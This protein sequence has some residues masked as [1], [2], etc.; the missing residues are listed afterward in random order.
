MTIQ[1]N[2]VYNGSGYLPAVG[3]I[4][5]MIR[6]EA[7]LMAVIFYLSG[8]GNSLY[9]AKTMAKEL[10]GC[11]LEGITSYLKAPYEVQDEVVGIVCPVYCMALPPVV[12]VFLQQ[13]KMVPQYIFTVVTMG[14]MSGQAL[15]QA[16]ELLEQ[17]ELR[18]AYG[19]TLALPDNSIVFPSPKVRQEKL[20]NQAPAEL[21]LIVR[22][23]KNR[24]DNYNHLSRSF[25]WQY[26]G[27]AIG[28]WVLNSIK[29]VG[30]LSCDAAKCVGC[31]ICATVCPAGNI[32]LDE[33]KPVFGSACV[34]C[35]GCAHWCPQSAISLGSLTPDAK[36]RYTH[37][38]VKPI[39]MEAQKERKDEA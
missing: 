5:I 11:R 13:V 18:L 25:L 16:K 22:N 6:S 8:T 26:G 10:E 9:A 2:L 23:I 35:F 30:Q 17:R 29:Q 3:S 27:T 20:L 12:E 15:G 37:P 39:D 32:T 4:S 14:A 38:E 24:H 33:G 34:H 36:T 21:G 31:G 19:V 28:W 1:V 7:N